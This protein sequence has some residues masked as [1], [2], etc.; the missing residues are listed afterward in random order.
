MK[1]IFMWV[2]PL[3]LF[4]ASAYLTDIKTYFAIM[5]MCMGY[6]MQQEMLKTE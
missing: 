2:I 3:L 5:F 4:S 1:F 6:W